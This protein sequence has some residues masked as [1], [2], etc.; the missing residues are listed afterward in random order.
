MAA[1]A[2]GQ[3]PGRRSHRRFRLDRTRCGGA[4]DAGRRIIA[5]IDDYREMIGGMSEQ[6]HGSPSR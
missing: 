4:E 5:A 1:P 2:I 6:M 3:T